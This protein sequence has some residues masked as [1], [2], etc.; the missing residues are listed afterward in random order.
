MAMRDKSSRDRNGYSV[1]TPH[2]L[3]RQA[4]EQIDQE[5]ERK[6]APLR[7]KL[8]QARREHE[9][10]RAAV[11]EVRGRYA[12]EGRPLPAPAFTRQDLV[13][14]KRIAKEMC[15]VEALH[16]IHQYELEIISREPGALG[17]MLR[18]KAREEV[19]AW[20]KFYRRLKHLN[21]EEANRNGIGFLIRDG[22][23]EGFYMCLEHFDPKYR[24]VLESPRVFEP[25]EFAEMRAY[26]EGRVNQ[27]ME[28]CWASTEK[29][30]AY[31]KAAQVITENL[32]RL[33]PQGAA[34]TAGF[35][36]EDLDERKR[37]VIEL[38]LEPEYKA[39]V[40]SLLGIG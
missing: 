17:R 34:I 36:G 14:M 19:D 13:R 18:R 25:R 32:R 12:A 31:A 27:Y 1:E 16:N 5:N 37:L 11:Q 4:I 26:V 7:E 39:R 33:H 35:K 20:L 6:A 30:L 40:E 23:G 9:I 2:E 28:S 38:A 29:A 24:D 8:E 21:D 22:S 15:S 3:G 10:A